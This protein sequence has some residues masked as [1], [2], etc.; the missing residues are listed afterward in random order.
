MNKQSYLSMAIT[1]LLLQ[2]CSSSSDSE[3]ISPST[4]PATIFNLAV[5]DAPVDEAMQVVACFS[6][7]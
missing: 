6:Q 4:L 5:S 3:T 7:I 2:A 1:S